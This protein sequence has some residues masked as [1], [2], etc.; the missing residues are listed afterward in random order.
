MGFSFDDDEVESAELIE[1]TRKVIDA[2]TPA[3]EER[4]F[5]WEKK[6]GWFRRRSGGIHHMFYVL[7]ADYAPSCIVINAD[8]GVRHDNVERIFHR[9]SGF[10]PNFHAGTPTVGGKFAN[11][12]AGAPGRM[13]IG[14]EGDVSVSAAAA[15]LANAID[16]AETY[17]TRFSSLVEIDQELNSHPELHSPNRVLP[18]FRCS[19]GLI[20]AKLVG[21]DNYDRLVVEYQKQLAA[22]NGGFYLRWFSELVRDLDSHTVAELLD[23]QSATGQLRSKRRSP[24]SPRR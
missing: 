24:Q 18:W 11:V 9:T 15:R 4:G 13:D 16:L 21:R 23:E 1:V 12:M 20:V 22:D 2:L 6:H 8:V 3:F 19:A 10:D 7:F 14:P 17:F 5:R